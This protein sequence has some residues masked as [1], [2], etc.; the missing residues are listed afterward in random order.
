V[1]DENIFSKRFELAP[2]SPDFL[3]LNANKDNALSART[4]KRLPDSLLMRE[5]SSAVCTEVKSNYA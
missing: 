2:V 1:L 3:S 4:I 5:E